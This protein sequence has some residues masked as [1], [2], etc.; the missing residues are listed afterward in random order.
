MKK[1]YVIALFFAM[2]LLQP[3]IANAQKS[4]VIELEN[5]KGVVEE[6]IP[7][8]SDLDLLKGTVEK[9]AEFHIINDIQLDIN[10]VD[11]P[12]RASS[13]LTEGTMYLENVNIYGKGK[14]GKLEYLFNAGGRAT[15]DNRIDGRGMTITSLKGQ[16]IYEDHIL[17]AG[18]VFESFSQY[19]LNTNLKGVSY[20]FFD[21]ADDLPDIT[22]VYGYAYPRWDSLFKADN[23]KTMQRKAYGLNVR[24]DIDYNLDVGFSFVRSEDDDRQ[25]LTETQYNNNIYSMDYDYRPIP[26]LTIRGENAF[27][28]GERELAQNGRYASYFGHAHRIEAIGVG[29]PSRVTMGYEYVNPK[30]ETLV[31]SAIRGRQKANTKWKYQISKNTTM[32]TSFLWYQTN[33]GKGTQSVQTFR[34]ELGFTQRQ[35]LNRRYAQASIDYKL[36]MNSGNHLKSNDHF[37]TMNYRDRLGFLDMDNQFGFNTFNTTK[38][39]RQAFEYNYHTSLSTRHRMGEFVFK[40]SVNAGTYFIDDVIRNS[41]DKIVEYSVGLGVDIPKYRLNTN[42]KFGQN[43]LNTGLGTDSDKLFTSISIYYK[44]SFVGFLNASTFFLRVAINDYNFSARTM[45]FS[46]KSISMG[47]NMPVDLFVGKKK[48]AL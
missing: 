36:N 48:E 2:L 43:I 10:D 26:G 32:D 30:F 8:E 14:H 44:P 1:S 29:G 39:T 46:E 22:A 37:I 6:N 5:Y 28:N 27:N 3:K 17:S 23:V 38:R 16:A 7:A 15:N 11:G 33:L 25:F 21:P 41:L 19:S 31:G 18:D 47:M 20:K 35:F 42:M 13:S 4:E 34:P 12:G 40:P 9:Y 24:K 45:N